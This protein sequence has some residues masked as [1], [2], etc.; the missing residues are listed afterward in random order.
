MIYSSEVGTSYVNRRLMI[1]RL[2]IM[3]CH[4]DNNGEWDPKL[5]TFISIWSGRVD[6]TTNDKIMD[7]TCYNMVI[8][9]YSKKPYQGHLT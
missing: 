5:Y 8:M 4:G 2:D 6:R 3:P 7:D 1:V 9:V